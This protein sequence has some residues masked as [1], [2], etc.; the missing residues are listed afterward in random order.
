[1]NDKRAKVFCLKRCPLFL[2]KHFISMGA[3]YEGDFSF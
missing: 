2:I 1:M 3:G